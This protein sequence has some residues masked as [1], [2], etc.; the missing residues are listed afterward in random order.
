MEQS[1][2]NYIFAPDMA[3]LKEFDPKDK[4]EKARD[5]FWKKGYYATSMQDLVNDM[6]INRGSMYDTFGDK[7]KLFIS[8]L[9]SYV[10][11]T[12]DEY[13]KVISGETSP[14]KSIE[15]IIQK[16]IK[17][18]FEESKVCMVVKTSFELAPFDTGVKELLQQSTNTLMGIFEELLEKAK[19]AGE[20]DPER[21]VKEAAAFI[22][23]TFAGFWQMQSLYDNRKMIDQ[24]AKNLMD[25]LH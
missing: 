2:N 24:L 5:L 4:L 25:Y 12:H 22:V 17:R 10:A 1:F 16:A 7:H 13:K 8:S 20:F 19:Q 18:S 3:R 23:A 14:I 15:K 6:K 21:D 11:E 9:E